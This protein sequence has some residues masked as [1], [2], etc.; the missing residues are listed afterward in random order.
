MLDVPSEVANQ[1]RSPASDKARRRQARKRKALNKRLRLALGGTATAYLAVHAGILPET[2][3]PTIHLADLFEG[4]HAVTL[5]GLL[6]L[7]LVL[8][9]YRRMASSVRSSFL[10]IVQLVV[11]QVIT[12][13]DRRGSGNKP[14]QKLS[15]PRRARR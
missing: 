10:R 14:V 7:T 13:V 5:A 3:T 4:A 9:A 2:Y 6:G 1:P 11:D 12:A 15:R 8:S